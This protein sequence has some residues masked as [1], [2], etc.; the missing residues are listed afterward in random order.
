VTISFNSIPVGIRQPGSYVEFANTRAQQGLAVWNTRILI[1][2]QALAAGVQPNYAP[3]QITSRLDGV[4]A[5]G[6]G[7]MLDRMIRKAVDANSFT[8]MW[9]MS[10]PDNGA[11]VAATYTTTFTAQP[12][13]GGTLSRYI[14]GQ[15]VQIAVTAGMTNNAMAAALAAAINANAD[16]PL[17]ATA[18][19]AV[20]TST[21]RW[22]GVTGNA[23]D[24]R[25]NYWSSDAMPAGL[26]LTDAAGTAGSGDPDFTAALAP[27]GDKQYQIIVFPWS[28]GGDLAELTTEL[29][30][31]AG[32]L[33]MIDGVAIC[34]VDGSQGAL[35]TIGAA[36][37]SKWLCLPEATGP[38]TVW[39]RAAVEAAVAIFNLTNDP[40]R[41]LQTLALPG[42]LAPS[43]AEAF[44]GTQR[45][46][47]LHSGIS[48]HTVDDG[49][50]VMIQRLITTYQL[51]AQGLPDPSYLDITTLLT[52]SYLRF[53]LRV[54]FA[55]K[56]PRVKIAK[57]G[58]NAA[59]G[60][61][62]VTL[63]TLNAELVALA[64]EWE[65]AGL[66][67]DVDTFKKLLIIQ[68]DPTDDGRVN[69]VI[70]PDIIPGLRVF[71]AQIDFAI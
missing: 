42:E 47:L 45:E 44:T 22:K 13:A 70:P 29:D 39:E 25:S 49:G 40:A 28:S 55:Q 9:A 4:L 27:L 5:F 17:T 46:A 61:A 52:L 19:G 23:L 51:N 12:T 65:A 67:Q 41:P 66:V 60:T 30:S 34:G 11:G 21:V 69:A 36:Q 32:G 10:V 48:T 53:T 16:L 35:S 62:T 71:A 33:R 64:R 59:P 14:A 50:Q 7:S 31:R 63:S 57:D 3:L 56:F 26:A 68:I 2:G 15:L 58:T 37:N 54:R 24:I 20:V 38:T 1:L 8:E 6:R 18:A 43:Q